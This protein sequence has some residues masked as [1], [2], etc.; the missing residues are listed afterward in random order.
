MDTFFSLKELY[1]EK[2]FEN[3]RE[4]SPSVDLSSSRVLEDCE[5]EVARGALGWGVGLGDAGLGADP[6]EPVLL[7]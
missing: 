2:M 6:I 3:L 5:V 1:K 4:L 7:G